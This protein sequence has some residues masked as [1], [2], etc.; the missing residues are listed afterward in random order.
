MVKGNWLSTV[1]LTLS[2]FYRRDDLGNK[3]LHKNI[4]T[5]YES[6]S[7]CQCARST[8]LQGDIKPKQN[9]SREFAITGF[10]CINTIF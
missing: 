10:D 1:Q 5:A 7:F 9:A 4:P 2:N 6:T 3:K 8:V